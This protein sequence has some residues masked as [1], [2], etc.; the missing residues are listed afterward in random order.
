MTRTHEPRIHGSGMKKLIFFE[1]PEIPPDPL[2][3]SR[4][5]TFASLRT[6]GCRL[7]HPCRHQDGSQHDDDSEAFFPEMWTEMEEPRLGCT[8]AENRICLTQYFCV[9]AKTLRMCL[10][11]HEGDDCPVISNFY[12]PHL[13]LHGVFK[14]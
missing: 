8:L 2:S 3:W 14:R 7:Q 4:P 9:V 12:C 10:R 6:P 5:V 13:S 11:K 1:I